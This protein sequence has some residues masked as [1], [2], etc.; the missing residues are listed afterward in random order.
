MFSSG[1]RRVKQVIVPFLLQQVREFS[2]NPFRNVITSQVRS[3]AICIVMLGFVSVF[4]RSSEVLAQE[5]QES[6]RDMKE[7]VGTYEGRTIIANNGKL[8]YQNQGMPSPVQL[9]EIADDTFEIVI[10]A[11]AIVRGATDGKFPTIKFKRNE[12]GAVEILEFVNPDGSVKG[13]YSKES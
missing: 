10:P 4:S 12:S 1:K 13:S 11:G 8:S 3:F 9:K 6:K 5:Q 7:Y 2:M